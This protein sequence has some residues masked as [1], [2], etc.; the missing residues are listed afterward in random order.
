[1]LTIGQVRGWAF[2][3]LKL[4]RKDFYEMRV[5]EFFEALLAFR[6]EK[7]ADRRHLGE[8]VRGATLRLINIQLR[9]KDRMKDPAKFWEM[10]WDETDDEN[11]EEIERLNSLTDEERTAEAKKFLE[12]IDNGKK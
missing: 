5:G 2:G 1:M 7:E 10:P 6:E 8:L 12:L 3:L 11:Q 9:P 4:S